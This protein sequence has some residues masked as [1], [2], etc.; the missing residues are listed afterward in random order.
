MILIKPV[1]DA[2]PCVLPHKVSDGRVSRRFVAGSSRSLDTIGP[3][4]QVGVQI[5]H[6]YAD[7]GV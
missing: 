1:R 4:P 5:Q 2:R 6:A 3:R 7:R